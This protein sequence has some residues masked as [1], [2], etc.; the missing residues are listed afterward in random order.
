MRKQLA[1][2]LRDNRFNDQLDWEDYGAQFAAR[3]GDGAAAPAD[4]EP[5]RNQLG[6][7]VRA[8]LP[9]YLFAPLPDSDNEVAALAHPCQSGRSCQCDGA[10]RKAESGGSSGDQR[11]RNVDFAQAQSPP[12]C[13][14]PRAKLQSATPWAQSWSG[15]SGQRPTRAKQPWSGNPPPRSGAPAGEGP[16]NSGSGGPNSGPDSPGPSGGGPPLPG[17]GG[18]PFTAPSPLPGN[19]DADPASLIR[20]PGP[21]PPY[22]STN[23]CKGPCPNGTF[24]YKGACVAYLDIEEEACKGTECGYVAAYICDNGKED[25]IGFICGSCQDGKACIEGGCKCCCVSGKK[26]GVCMGMNEDACL[27]KDN[28]ENLLTSWQC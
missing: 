4:A 22:C 8:G 11:Y 7:A 14:A 12:A 10:C 23:P 27:L 28:V 18:G 5:R 25:F 17:R 21:K 15:T 19:F 2:Y 9:A 3:Y 6:Q 20:P 24:C 26:P 1:A 16:Q 13:G